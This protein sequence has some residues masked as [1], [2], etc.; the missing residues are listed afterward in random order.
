M[1]QKIRKTFSLVLAGSIL[2]GMMSVTA[3]AAED[4]AEDDHLFA[5][6]V[7]TCFPEEYDGPTEAPETPETIGGVVNVETSSVI[8]WDG[9]P[10]ELDESGNP[11]NL[12][13]PTPLD[14][15]QEPDHY[16]EAYDPENPEP[17]YV[18]GEKDESMYNPDGS[19]DLPV[20]EDAVIDPNS[21]VNND[22]SN[23]SDEDYGIALTSF[24]TPEAGEGKVTLTVD[25]GAEVVALYFDRDTSKWV[26]HELIP[27]NGKLVFYEKNFVDKKEG[28]NQGYA[29][30]VLFLCKPKDDKHLLTDLKAD[31][32]GWFTDS[33]KSG[34]RYLLDTLIGNKNNT[35]LDGYPNE[36]LNEMLEAYK[37][38]GFLSVFGFARDENNESEMLNTNATVSAVKPTLTVIATL[39]DATEETEF[40]VGDTVTWTVKVTS[41]AAGATGKVGDPT[42]T[43]GGKAV[44]AEHVVKNGD[45]TYTVT[46]TVQ[47]GDTKD[48]LKLNAT[49]DVTYTCVVDLTDGMMTTEVELTDV[50]GIGPGVV[51]PPGGDEEGEN[52]T[53]P[54]GGG[55]EGGENPPPP[56]GGDDEG[57]NPPPPPTGGDEG[58]ENPPPPSGGDDEGENPPPPSGGDEGGENPPPPSGGDDDDYT[59]RPQ[60]DPVTDIEE[61]DTP[62]TD[63]P[64]EDTPLTD[65]PEEDTPLTDIPE[66]DTP[67]TDLPQTG[68]VWGPALLL[69]L[70]GAGFSAAGLVKT[71]KKEDAE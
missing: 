10:I 33:D 61:E 23:G 52:P 65:I 57:E 1:T 24:E 44:P 46:Y 54:P 43:I 8:G 35:K 59:P 41:N 36:N 68:A 51:T 45:G 58:G 38:D 26:E 29:G 37:K 14:P 49:A 69:S 9:D 63:I 31:N 16:Q 13:A 4:P 70:L 53:P 28:E 5:N 12:P 6:E 7:E 64:E 67:L 32:N 71:R 34:D 21:T 60:P 18:E 48:T 22:G 39:E 55:D 40:K 3:L 2:T 30:H 56:S 20:P 19:W 11:I 47:E 66:E 27:E 25:E 42:I 50:G 15:E 62:L 17:Q